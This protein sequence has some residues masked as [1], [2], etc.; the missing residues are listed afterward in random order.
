MSSQEWLALALAFGLAIK[1]L[2]ASNSNCSWEGGGGEGGTWMAEEVD[3]IS[4]EGRIFGRRL[5]GL[6][7][8]H[9]P[10]VTRQRISLW[11]LFENFLKIKQNYRIPMPHTLCV[12]RTLK[13]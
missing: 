9:C 3:A 4:A 7:I 11:N 6:C 5:W 10:A 8:V 2:E 1:L 12:I 13:K